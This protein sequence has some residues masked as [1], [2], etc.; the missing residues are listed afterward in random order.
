MRISDISSLR[1]SCKRQEI[2]AKTRIEGFE[3]LEKLFKLTKGT[4]LSRL[5]FGTLCE[6][7]QQSVFKDIEAC[8]TDFGK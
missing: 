8:G 6:C 3:Y 5:T 1:E 2:W 4:H 7:L